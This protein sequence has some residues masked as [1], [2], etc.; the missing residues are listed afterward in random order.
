MT[1]SASRRATTALAVMGLLWRRLRR[2]R[3]SLAFSFALPVAVAV[4][5]AGI[6]GTDYAS[7]G[8]VVSQR[9]DPVG[10][11]IYRRLDGEG[12]VEATR[13]DT[14]AD[15]ERAVLRREVAAGL[16]VPAGAGDGT[17]T[18]NVE[19]V[20]QPGVEAPSG[21]RAVVESVVAETAA[22]LEVGRATDPGAP[23]AVALRRGAAALE[24]APRQPAGD[25][26]SESRRRETVAWAMVGALVLFVFM[27]T[28]GGAGSLAEL[29]ELG[30]L[31]RARTTP[32]TSGAVALGYGA[33]LASYALVQAVLMLA[34]GWL[35]FGVT[36][37]SWPA[38][39]VMVTV[40]A[41]SAAA[42][43]VLLATLL[44]SADLGT[45]VVGPV[46]FVLGMLGGCLWPLE[47]V[48]PG[49][50][51]LGHVTPH[52]W[53]VEALREVGVSGGG[54]GRVGAQLAVLVA[55]TVL[56]LV[57]GG[58]RLRRIAAHAV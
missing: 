32:A 52:A 35:L 41:A 30:I 20:G 19:L 43:A 14:R 5:M 15:L 33:G 51:R 4:V 55:A 10:E 46:A 50:A 44:P 38:L 25:T 36:W 53:A 34:T 6:Y 28:L 17:G 12:L 21:V 27:N 24:D 47:I 45:T 22:A 57:L 2:D 7:V 11:E 29:R 56:F 13:Y 1:G 3:T 26:T 39:V 58:L 48:G 23:A 42:L 31:A 8:V 18:S 16:V 37:A 40:V 9:D 49:L 54:L